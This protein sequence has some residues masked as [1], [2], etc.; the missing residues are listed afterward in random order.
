M[1]ESFLKAIQDL[2]RIPDFIQTEQ[3]CIRYLQIIEKK[4]KHEKFPEP[5]NDECCINPIY[6]RLTVHIWLKEAYSKPRFT[7]F[8]KFFKA[9]F[10][11]LDGIMQED[12][13]KEVERV[14]KMFVKLDD[15]INT[16]RPMMR[17]EYS[18]RDESITFYINSKMKNSLKQVELRDDF[19]VKAKGFFVHETT[20]HQQNIKSDGK[21]I[22]KY[23]KVDLSA[24]PTDYKYFNQNIEADAYGRQVGQLLLS[25]CPNVNYVDLLNMLATGTL[26]DPECQAIL[27]IFKNSEISKEVK[28]KFIRAVHDFV[29]GLED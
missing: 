1:Q 13:W 16:S 4:L 18:T 14:A 8:D 3:D 19:L 24:V 12:L 11:Y 6:D 9:Y 28:E 27:D 10:L 21:Y 17:A 20:H 26:P 5:E 22:L 2:S 15:K 7:I 29:A 25:R 23:K